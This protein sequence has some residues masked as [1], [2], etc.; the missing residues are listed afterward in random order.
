MNS[1]NRIQS[2]TQ[3]ITLSEKK[4]SQPIKCVNAM[5]GFNRAVM[6][7]RCALIGSGDISEDRACARNFDRQLDHLQSVNRLQF[8]KEKDS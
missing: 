7:E 1:I 6:N 4:S 2:R 5:F 3:S 8:I